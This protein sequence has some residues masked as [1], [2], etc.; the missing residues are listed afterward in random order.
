MTEFKKTIFIKKRKYATLDTSD[1]SSV[2]TI[3][4]K[5]ICLLILIASLA[6]GCDKNEILEN[7]VSACADSEG[8]A[9]I[10]SKIK[11][12]QGI[13]G[14]VSFTSGNC[15]PRTITVPGSATIPDPRGCQ[16]C[17]VSRTVKIYKYTTNSNAIKGN[18]Q[19]G[20]FYERFTTEFV[21][22]TKS[23]ANGFFQLSLP[24]GTYTMV[25]VENGLLYAP[26]GDEQGGINP[27]TVS[28][29]TKEINFRITYKAAF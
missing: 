23:D 15:M 19:V 8:F 26:F 10:D 14:V 17:P 29:G 5:K 1:G 21:A 9:P 20:P 12:T 3:A 7:E 18:N 2:K 11:I 22:E 27:I 13:F 24:A 4:M 6:I 28:S 16:T 25:V